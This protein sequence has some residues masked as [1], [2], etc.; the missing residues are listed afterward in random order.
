MQVPKIS[1]NWKII[2]NILL[3]GTLTIVA[4]INLFPFYWTFLSAFKS[5][6]DILALPPIFFPE[7]LTLGLAAPVVCTIATNFS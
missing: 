6:Q 2:S 4:I 3:Y 7:N 5:P 1:I